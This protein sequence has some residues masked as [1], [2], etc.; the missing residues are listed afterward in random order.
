MLALVKMALRNLV[1]HKAKSLIVGTIVSLGAAILVVGLSSIN[2]AQQGLARSFVRDFTGHVMIS[3]ISEGS[4]SL[5]G[6]QSIGGTEA[7]PVLPRV[8]DIAAWLRSQPEVDRFTTQLTGASQINVEQNDTQDPASLAFLFGIDADGYHV[9]FDNLDVVSGRYLRPGEPGVLF[10]VPQ[11]RVLERQL[12]TKIAVGDTVLLQN[13]GTAVRAVTVRG[14]FEFKRPQAAL[15]SVS[16]VDPAMLRALAGVGTDWDAPG[17][18]SNAWHFIIVDLKNAADAPRFIA[19][20]DA[21]LSREG[22]AAQASGWQRAAGPFATIPSM[23]R[24]VFMAAVFIVSVVAVIIIMN[25]LVA[26]VIERTSEIGT[27]RALGARKGFVWRM[28]F[29]ETLAISIVFGLIGIA[30]GSGLIGILNAAG[31]P[32]TNSLL[33]VIAGSSVLRPVISA[34]AIPASIVVMLVIAVIAHL[35]PVAV[36][37]KVQPVRAIQDGQNS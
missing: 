32:A 2:T 5:Y 36:A 31:I 34:T 22:I 9:M 3:G 23:I 33:R 25:T 29:L 20:T 12:A 16:Y 35:Y 6:V 28:F 10:S 27:M 19:R 26:S 14:I 7:T 15:D 24:A 1:A 30:V 4:I 17:N 11:I 8:E 21:W 37:L 13:F 18:A